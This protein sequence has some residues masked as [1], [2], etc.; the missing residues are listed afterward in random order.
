MLLLSG[1]PF[2]V[3][4]PIKFIR[5]YNSLSALCDVIWQNLNCQPMSVKDSA[6]V[7]LACWT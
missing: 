4:S 2:K 6:T 3:I 5:S 1:S 7:T